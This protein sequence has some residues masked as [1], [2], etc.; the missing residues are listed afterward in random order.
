MSGPD[1]DRYAVQIHEGNCSEGCPLIRG[2][3]SIQE[4]HDK[5]GALQEQDR[6]NGKGT[7]IYVDNENRNDPT[8][9]FHVPETHS[10]TI[11]IIPASPPP[12]RQDRRP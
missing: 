1:G 3:M 8:D 7:E 5:M 10:G 9:N 12:A 6:K 11:I 4:V 2:S